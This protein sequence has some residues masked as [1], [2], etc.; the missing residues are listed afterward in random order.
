MPKVVLAVGLDVEV[1]RELQ[2]VSRERDKPVSR[3]VNDA[4]S[5]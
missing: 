4:V 5:D 1:A 2:R 3:I